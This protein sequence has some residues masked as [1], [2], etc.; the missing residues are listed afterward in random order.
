MDQRW[1]DAHRRAT[2]Y[3]TLDMKERILED[4]EI[5]EDLRERLWSFIHGDMGIDPSTLPGDSE[6][7][8]LDKDKDSNWMRYCDLLDRKGWPDKVAQSIEKSTRKAM[9]FLF[10]PK[11]EVVESK[12]GLVVGHV[13]SGKTANYTGL[14]ARAA[15]SGYNVIIVL[16][17]LHNNLRKQTQIRLERELMGKDR[18]DLH[19]NPPENYDWVKITT[20][21]DDFQT[22][23]D[24]GFLSGNNPVIAVVKK[25]V[26][27]LT[28]LHNMF[29]NFSEEKRCKL[30]LLMI[31]DESD[32]AT[33][34]TKKKDS[35]ILEFDFDEYDDEE[36]EEDDGEITNATVIN[37]R[38]RQI[39]GL[40]PRS[41]YVGYTATPFANVLINPEDDH[42]SLGKT[43][44]PRDFIM[45]LPKPDG[46]L[47]LNEFFPDNE[48]M[49]QTHASQVRVVPADQAEELRSFESEENDV[50]D[51]NIPES[52]E[53]AIIDYL[54]SGA[55]RSCRSETN[56]HHSMLIHTKHTIR[57]QSPVAD[58]VSVL[59]EYWNN[60]LV[61]EYSPEG[62][63]LC[64][65]FRQ[66]WESDFAIHPLTKES[67]GEVHTALMDFIHNGYMIMEI[68]SSSE[69][70]LDYDAYPEGL[71]VIAVGGN[72]LSRGLTLEGLCSTFFIR[73]TRMYDTLTQ[74]GRW[75]GFRPGYSDLVR[76]HITSKLLEWFTWLTGVERELRADIERYGETGK[77]PDALAVRI[78]KHRKMLPT[79]R[80]KMRSARAFAAGLGATCPRT[81]KFP[82]DSHFA[83]QSN[84]RTTASFLSNLGDSEFNPA[85]RLWRGI[86]PDCV[87]SL[88][89]GFITHEEDNS[90]NEEDIINHINQRVMAGELSSWSVGLINNSK[91]N[92]L[93]PFSKYGVDY[94]FGLSTRSRLRGRDSIGELMQPIHFAMDLPGDLD[95]YRDGVSFSYTKMYNSRSIDNPLL[96]IY[97]IDKDS[98][99]SIQAKQA[100]DPLFTDNQQ[101][102]HVIGLAIA[103][104]ETNMTDKEREQL[105]EFW[106][107][108]GVAHEP[109]GESEGDS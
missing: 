9:N 99:V 41:A 108:G 88:L 44:Y 94:E 17:G 96:L 43:L 48:D 19:V 2:A 103:F 31:D 101:K 16:A 67:W 58:K 15:D 82:L 54:L 74:M 23:P 85:G 60:H 45:A 8:Y 106:A 81:K 6:E 30:N 36:D 76:V 13:Q 75:F 7:W 92:I 65:R 105:R 51:F 78:L 79:S 38:L 5:P 50:P 11:A 52:L 4:P 84:L 14:I 53:N 95:Q 70:N 98:E 69:H 87:I 107:L 102:E 34:N 39:L 35:G 24:S 56:F 90:F 46:H 47:G 83:L 55:A 71:K 61:N 28:K 32:H 62:K 63:E 104:P 37:T 12:Y 25:N 49:D 40:F 68:N 72:R 91:G 97:T 57:S 27:P 86:D 18:G 66:R 26:S 59:T 1:H 22:L 93:K 73:E 89:Q 21:E 3:V 77:K 100:R 64:E 42:E 20:Q 10:N 33:I 109:E 29:Y 80:S